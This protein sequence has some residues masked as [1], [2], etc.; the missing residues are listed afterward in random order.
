MLIQTSQLDDTQLAE[1]D[2][3]CAECNTVDKNT[4]TIYRHLLGTDRLRPSSLMY[5]DDK[6]KKLIGFLGAFFF[7]EGTCEIALMVAPSSRNRAI[8]SQLLKT[9]LP[10]TQLE[11]IQHF[12]FSSPHGLNDPWFLGLGMHY[13]HSEFEMRRSDKQPIATHDSCVTMTH[14]TDSD[15]PILCAID[16]ICFSDDRVDAATRLYGL[17][18]DPAYRIFVVKKNN[19]IIGKAHINWQP[20]V[21]RVSDIAIIP[22]A[23]GNGF[24]KALLIHCIN[25][26]LENSTQDIILDVE[27]TNKKALHLYTGRGFSITNA[28]DYWRISEFGLTDFL[29]RL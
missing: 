11:N 7:S 26:A 4:V 22:N 9:I 19:E 8:A 16:E 27:T 18:H 3:L 25:H 6:T 24:G 15:I 1:L 14:A 29:Q 21:T 2:T 5:F 28:H 17:L 12:I 13:Q 20:N 23:Q 10:L